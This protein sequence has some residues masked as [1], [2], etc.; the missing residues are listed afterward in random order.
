MRARDYAAA[1]MGVLGR[2]F[3]ALDAYLT[4]ALPGDRR[5]VTRTAEDV[6]AWLGRTWRRCLADVRTRRY[7]PGRGLIAIV[8]NRPKTETEETATHG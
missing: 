1:V 5:T 8:I 3:L 4:A 7:G 6:A 2:A